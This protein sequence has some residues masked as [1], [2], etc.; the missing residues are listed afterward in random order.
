MSDDS[1]L[2]QAVTDELTEQV[3]IG[4][5]VTGDDVTDQLDGESLGRSVGEAVGALLGRR[6][7][8]DVVERVRSK[9]PFGDGREVDRG[10]LG[11]LGAALFVALVRTLRKPQ[12]SEPLKDSLREFAETREEQLSD[13]KETG[14]DAAES[15]ADTADEAAE[16][17]ADAADEDVNIGDLNADDMAALR[18]E[19][20]RELLEMMEYSKL[21][22]IA[23]EVGVQANLKRETMI[24]NLVEA[25]E[26]NAAD[27]SDE[28]TDGNED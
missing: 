12:F 22:S 10:P 23:K 28:S 16:P 4:D 6:V 25:F 7:A 1:N 19:T 18:Q 2:T 11:R 21:Q 17:V 3:D 13:A 24:D 14:E 9:L 26:E 27:E 15:A 5:L 20:Y 8:R